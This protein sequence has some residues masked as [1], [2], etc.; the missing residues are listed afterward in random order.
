MKKI[1][2]ILLS[3]FLVLSILSISSNPVYA[4]KRVLNVKETFQEQ[5]QWCWAGVSQAVLKFYKKNKSQGVIA[6]Y[7]WG[8]KDCTNT[9]VPAVCNQPNYMY[10]YKGSIEDILDHWRV[11]STPI[12]KHLR[13]NEVKKQINNKLISPAVDSAKKKGYP[14][15]I[16]YGWYS[17]GGHFIIIRGYDTAGK[18]LYLMNPWFTEGYGIYKYSYVKKE[19]YDHDWT[20]TL[21][22]IKKK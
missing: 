11:S 15:I 20:H 22:N 6:N 4:K 3:I 13:W 8:R 2:S 19:P 16:R 9:P 10:Y 5:T 1:V 21:Y 14:Q 18:K 17:G 12:A 7:A